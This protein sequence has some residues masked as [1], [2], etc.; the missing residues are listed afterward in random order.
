M[1]L[2]HLTL[3]MV[4]EL[5]QTGTPPNR[6]VMLKFGSDCQG[7]KRQSFYRRALK[8]G[9]RFFQC[10]LNWRLQKSS[11]THSL[12]DISIAVHSVEPIAQQGEQGE[13]SRSSKS[14]P[15]AVAGGSLGQVSTTAVAGGFLM[16]PW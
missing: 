1:V 14:V 9:S 15:P 11:L 12:L 7:A 16:V 2:Y 8:P 3:Q 13:Y 5:I 10:R 6:S 4:T